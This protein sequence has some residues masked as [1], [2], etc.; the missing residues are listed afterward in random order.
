M[1]IIK[2]GL[3]VSPSKASGVGGFRPP[4]PVAAGASLVIPEGEASKRP[5]Q[6]CWFFVFYLHQLQEASFLRCFGKIQNPALAGFDMVALAEK[7]GF[8][9][10]VRLPGQRFSR[11]PRSTTPPFLRRKDNLFLFFENIF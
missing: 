5:Y 4:Q 6:T 2:E 8:E 3:L 7:E 11:P 9:P 1:N 10:P